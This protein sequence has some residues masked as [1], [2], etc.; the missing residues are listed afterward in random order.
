MTDEQQLKL[1]AFLD[2]E[3][4]ESDS[5]EIS[6]LLER[7][8]AALKSVRTRERQVTS[9]LTIAE[10]LFP[11]LA[12]TLV[13]ATLR[14]LPVGLRRSLGLGCALDR[15]DLFRLAAVPARLGGD[16]AIAGLA[17]PFAASAAAALGLAHAVRDGSTGILRVPVR[18]WGRGGTL[19][20]LYLGYVL[21]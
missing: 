16:G 18:D 21:L 14:G 3:L 7:D 20:R 17:L 19:V 11:A 9:A 10:L 5:R 4:P 15:R 2:G 1:Q 6:A 13:L 8:A 12:R